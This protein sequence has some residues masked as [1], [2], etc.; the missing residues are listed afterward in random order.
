MGLTDTVN[1]VHLYILLKC[2][3]W[4]SC[5]SVQAILLLPS[6]DI[7][8][9]LFQ[10]IRNM[11]LKQWKADENPGGSKSNEHIWHY[12]WEHFMIAEQ[13]VEGHVWGN[14]PFYLWVDPI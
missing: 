12:R 5:T 8:K 11:F 6:G 3:H 2:K 13:I 9:L 1:Q 10:M 4:N 14:F 7:Q